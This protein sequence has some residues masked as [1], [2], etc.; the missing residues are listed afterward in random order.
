MI[1]EL[2]RAA[3]VRQGEELDLITVEAYLRERLPQFAVPTD[4]KR[5]TLRYFS[6]AQSRASNATTAAVDS[7]PT[8]VA[9]C[10]KRLVL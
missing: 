9:P 4:D 6:Q 2:D 10:Q 3:P 5:P 7:E 8:T 1:I